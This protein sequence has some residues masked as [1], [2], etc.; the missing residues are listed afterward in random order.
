MSFRS[1]WL[2]VLSVTLTFACERT[3][4]NY[5]ATATNHNCQELD[6]GTIEEDAEVDANIDADLSC[7]GNQDCTTPTPVCDLEGSRACVQC[8]AADSSA[9]SGTTP[10]C[11]TDKMCHGCTAHAQCDSDVCLPDGSCAMETS[12]AYVAP[13]PGGT[14]S[15]CTK[16]SPCRT[17]DAGLKQNRA[18]VK[19]ST[20]LVKDMKPTTIDGQAVIIFADAGAQLDRDG[21]GPIL[22][23]NGAGASV[24]LYDLEI[25]GASGAAGADGIRLTAN[26]GNPIVSLTRVTIDRN[27]GNG[28]SASG[29]TLSISQSSINGNQATGITIAD[30]TLSLSRSTVAANQGGG[31]AMTGA[32]TEFTIINNFIYQNGNNVT[33]SAGGLFLLPRGASKLEFNTIVDNQAKASGTTSAGGVLCD[34][35]DF[36]AA[37]NIIFRNTGGMAGNVQI[38]GV[39][40][41]GDSLIRPG[42][43]NVDNFP[44]FASPN[45]PPF[46]YHLTASSP[47]SIVDAS[48]ACVGSDFDGDMRPLGGVCDLGADERKP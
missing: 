23:V 24:Q 9:C 43:S 15:T 41:Y 8:T 6:A 17:L 22:E 28:I 13:G 1:H 44:G 12:V 20:G 38:V 30:G 35:R 29:G 5:C 18:Y 27:Q 40:T 2:V 31:I 45:A 25:T 3:H 11:D 32:G 39:C 48:G 47:A 26:G 21:D 33:T 34:E 16:S 10:L 7:H 42:T 46:D 36:V 37:H 4:P 14:D 19:M